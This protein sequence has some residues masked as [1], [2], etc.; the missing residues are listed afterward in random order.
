M[1]FFA[2][3]SVVGL[4]VLLPVNCSVSSGLS[5]TSRSMDTLTISNVP[6]GSNRYV[7][8]NVFKQNI[9]YENFRGSPNRC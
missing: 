7:Y 1:K 3:C 6:K 9:N 5:P 2:V 8:Q 4:M